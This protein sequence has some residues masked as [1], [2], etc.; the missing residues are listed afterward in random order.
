MQ[1]RRGLPRRRRAAGQADRTA[2]ARADTSTASMTHPPPARPPLDDDLAQAV[3][4]VDRMPTRVVVLGLIGAAA[5]LAIDWIYNHQLS[6]VAW[7]AVVGIATITIPI[8]DMSRIQRTVWRAWATD[9]QASRHAPPPTPAPRQRSART[10]KI[11]AARVGSGPRTAASAHLRI[12]PPPHDLSQDPQE[13][14]R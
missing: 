14:V 3:Q 13:V 8:V 12:T 1:A 10:N 6:V 9:V 2:R 7:I 4:R 11:P 5:M